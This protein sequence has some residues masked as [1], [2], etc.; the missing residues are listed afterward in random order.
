MS[1]SCYPRVPGEDRIHQIITLKSVWWV[2][3]ALRGSA[4]SSWHSSYIHFKLS[5]DRFRLLHGVPE[6][7][8]LIN[9]SFKVISD[10]FWLHP[11]VPASA[12]NM[13]FKLSLDELWLLSGVPRP[14]S[15]RILI[16][17]ICWWVWAANLAF[18]R[19]VSAPPSNMPRIAQNCI[20]Q[21]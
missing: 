11:G 8:Q 10:K 21:R 2:L 5:V 19:L 16:Q 4:R 20:A 13:N 6:Q 17:I 15:S 9:Y 3:L 7:Q 1:C 12:N 18:T 14:A